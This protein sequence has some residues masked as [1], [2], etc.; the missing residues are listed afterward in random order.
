MSE[1][2][3]ITLE[4]MKQLV[5]LQSL[6]P[7]LL[8]KIEA[9]EKKVDALKVSQA[10]LIEKYNENSNAIETYK[11]SVDKI[12]SSQVDLKDLDTTV[13]EIRNRIFAIEDSLKEK[14]EPKAKKEEKKE[15]RSEEVIEI[16]D[17]ILSGHR[18]RK[19][20]RLTLKDLTDGFNCSEEVGN[21]VLKWFE[22]KKMYN[23]KTSK[24]TFPKR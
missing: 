13:N 20:R 5:A 21:Q 1:E 6:L 16:C 8:D 2:K 17:K 18:G 4:E 10:K 9:I 24:L 3:E 11:E 19:E 12:L 14:K 23:P 7:A 15:T 22:E